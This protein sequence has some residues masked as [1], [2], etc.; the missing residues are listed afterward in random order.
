M[1][2]V[3]IKPGGTYIYHWALKGQCQLLVSPA[4]LSAPGSKTALVLR[5]PS[6]TSVYYTCKNSFILSYCFFFRPL[7]MMLFVL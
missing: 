2:F 5:N 7:T 3:D 4:V 6:G 1:Q